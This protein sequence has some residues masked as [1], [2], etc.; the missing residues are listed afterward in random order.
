[1]PNGAAQVRNPSYADRDMINIAGL[2]AILLIDTGHSSLL[3]PSSSNILKSLPSKLQI[4]KN[5]FL[6]P[7]VSSTPN[8]P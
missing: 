5:G 2:L 1:M 4:N 8:L 7:N 3:T 6:Q